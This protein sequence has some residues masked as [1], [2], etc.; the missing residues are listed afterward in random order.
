[1]WGS[2]GTDWGASDETT[3]HV[4]PPAG[5]MSHRETESD[6]GPEKD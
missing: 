5:P 4:G 6:I 1:M 3:C 2:G